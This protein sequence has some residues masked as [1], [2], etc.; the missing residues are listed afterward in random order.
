MNDKAT[1]NS[2]VS[3]N[4]GDV[5]FECPKCDKGLAVDSSAIG[6]VVECTDCGQLM[7]VPDDHGQA[8]GMHALDLEEEVSD[9]RV[10]P[11]EE[12]KDSGS[13]DSQQQGIDTDVMLSK[14]SLNLLFQELAA[15]QNALDQIVSVLGNDLLD[16]IGG[17]LGNDLKE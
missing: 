5:F 14:A 6:M 13:Q 8:E 4:E 16:H 2:D 12:V 3:A 15:I 11:A 10:R 9:A 1:D 7:R 17:A